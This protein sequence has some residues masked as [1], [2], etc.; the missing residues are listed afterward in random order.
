MNKEEQDRLISTLE[1]TINVLHN[2][3]DYEVLVRKLELCL[4]EA[5]ACNLELRLSDLRYAE[6]LTSAEDPRD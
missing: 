4:C 1:E 5:M 2:Q 6:Y 3:P